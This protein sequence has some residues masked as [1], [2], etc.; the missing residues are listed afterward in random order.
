MLEVCTVLVNSC[1]LESTVHEVAKAPSPSCTHHTIIVLIV[2]LSDVGLSA[3][4]VDANKPDPLSPHTETLW[5][6]RTHHW[7]FCTCAHQE[8]GQL[9]Q[10][11]GVG[12]VEEESD[13]IV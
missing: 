6:T 11:S 2:L 12:E 9:F 7:D 10:E 5:P 4:L 8:S 3:V 1:D 13:G